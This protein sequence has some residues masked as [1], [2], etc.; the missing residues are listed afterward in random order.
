MSL[1]NLALCY[2]AIV[3]SLDDPET[4]VRVHSALALSEMIRH[5]YGRKYLLPYTC[6][7]NAVCIV[8]DAVKAIIGKILQSKIPSRMVGYR[9]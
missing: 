6:I 5:T 1:K 4:P 9:R 8:Q 3:S 2:N 7:S